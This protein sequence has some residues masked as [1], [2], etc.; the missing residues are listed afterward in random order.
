MLVFIYINDY[1]RKY[2]PM[3]LRNVYFVYVYS[4]HMCLNGAYYKP[5]CGTLQ[6]KEL[7]SND[8][9]RLRWLSG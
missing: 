2:I 6:K 4:I 1:I 3:R 8:L 9:G 7:K 5:E